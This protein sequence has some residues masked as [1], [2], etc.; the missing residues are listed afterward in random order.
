M[1]AH[2]FQHADFESPAAIL[3]WLTKNNFEISYTNFYEN[4]EI[5]SI[6]NI[7]WLIIMGGPMSVN[8]EKEFP[9]LREEKKFIKQCI[10]SGKKVLGI[11]LGAQLIANVL[12]SSIYN[13]KQKEIGW[14]PLKQIADPENTFLIPNDIMVFHWH[15]E[16]FDLP[17]EARLL[18]ST[19]ACTNQI[20]QLHTNVLALQCHLEMTPQSIEGMLNNCSHEL[21]QAPFI[22]NT[23]EIREDTKKFASGANL[24]LYSLLDNLNAH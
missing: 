6:H 7:D 14:F 24:V 23:D 3:N 21:Y 12:G 10:H 15:G 4:A 13:G 16:T 2:I 5:P 1:R 8:D 22:Q 19:E 20:F 9:W 18:A 11:C 17:V